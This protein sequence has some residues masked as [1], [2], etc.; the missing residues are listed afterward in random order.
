MQFLV[1]AELRKTLK[2]DAPTTVK[3]LDLDG[4]QFQGKITFIDPRNEAGTVRVK[5]LVEN[6]EHRVKPGMRVEA[7]FAK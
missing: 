6:K 7:E 5:V 3:V 1:A 2:N 4:A